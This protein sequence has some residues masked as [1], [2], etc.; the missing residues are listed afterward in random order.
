[1]GKPNQAQ[2]KWTD[3]LDLALLREVLRVE[4]YDGEHGTL[5]QRWKEVAAS[6]SLYSNQGIP[7]RSVRDH[8]EGL[9]EA[10]KATDKSQRQ[11]A[12]TLKTA[13]KSKEKKR[14]ES[15]EST[16]SQLCV[17][18]EQRVSKR[19]RPMSA[20]R[21]QFDAMVDELLEFEKKKQM[22]DHRFRMGRLDFDREEQQLRQAQMAENAQR[23]AL[24]EKLFVDMGMLVKS[25][26]NKKE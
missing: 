7:H 9:V 18:A 26:V 15:L 4:P 11:L 8:Y 12:D 20:K 24:L 10:F 1:M 14:K 3:D 25:I 22:D 5:I 6:L 13:V 23:G 21:E 17:E 16:A 19:Q 2:L